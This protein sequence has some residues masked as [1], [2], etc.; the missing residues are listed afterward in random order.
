MFEGNLIINILKL[1]I[2]YE[3]H[4]IAKEYQS[5]KSSRSWQCGHK[6]EGHVNLDLKVKVMTIWTLR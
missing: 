2:I 4:Y 6:G 3:I 5:V 1:I